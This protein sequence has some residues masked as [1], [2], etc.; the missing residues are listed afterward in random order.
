MSKKQSVKRQNRSSDA[1]TKCQ[2]RTMECRSSDNDLKGYWLN[3]S[4]Q[5]IDALSRSLAIGSNFTPACIL[6]KTAEA[7]YWNTYIA[8]MH[9][10]RRS[11]LTI[12]SIVSVRMWCIFH[13]SLY[14]FPACCAWDF[15][16]T[17]NSLISH[18]MKAPVHNPID[19]ITHVTLSEPSSIYLLKRESAADHCWLTVT[20]LTFAT[21]VVVDKGDDCVDGLRESAMTSNAK[22]KLTSCR[23]VALILFDVSI[24]MSMHALVFSRTPAAK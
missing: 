14:P 16:R 5:W 3:E 2:R 21:G 20:T 15:I 4:H 10:S 7:L 17:L 22:Q 23:R 13:I 6:Y 8:D 1:H 12:W 9:Y 24:T 19:M 18:S 11:K